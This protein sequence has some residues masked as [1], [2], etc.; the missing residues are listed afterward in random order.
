MAALSGILKILRSEQE[1]LFAKH[2]LKSM[3]FFG[4]HAREEARPDSDVDIMVEFD[5]TKDYD[6]LELAWELQQLLRRKV[7]LVVRKGVRPW[8]L[9]TI[10]RDLLYV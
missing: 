3:A 7:D 1:R 9:Q 4:S 8:Y 10:D 2:A 6:F 5:T